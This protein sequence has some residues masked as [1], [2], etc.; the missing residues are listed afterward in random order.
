MTPLPEIDPTT[1]RDRLAKGD[2]LL[3]LDVREPFERG[4]ADLPDHDQLRIPVRVFEASLD[5]I[6]AEREVVL[7][8]RSGSRSGWAAEQLLANG[9]ERVW[10]L[11]G[12]VLAWRE[13]VDPTLTAY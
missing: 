7:Y 10:N 5:Q 2:S 8:C 6:D 11:R 4:I 13:D 9:F 1:L 12:G 3:L